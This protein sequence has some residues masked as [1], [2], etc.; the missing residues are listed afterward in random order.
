[1]VTA[2]IALGSNIGDRAAHLGHAVSRLKDL[3]DDLRVSSFHETVPVDTPRPQPFFLNA[4]A[5]GQVALSARE[6]LDALL[7]IERERWRER[8][9]VNAPRTLDLDLVLFGDAMVDEP[10]LFV[11]HPRFRQRRFVLA[12][13]AEIAPDMR[14]PVTGLTISE[15][16]RRLEAEP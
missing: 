16:L 13:L 10:G 7:A 2:A 1:M 14:D 9:H 12:P 5:T 11:P 3:L 6:L 15:L 4:G 8:P